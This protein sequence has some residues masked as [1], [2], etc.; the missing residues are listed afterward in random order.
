MWRKK[1]KKQQQW[2]GIY[3][4]GKRVPCVPVLLHVVTVQHP[5]SSSVGA[6]TLRACP[7][8]LFFFFCTSCSSAAYYVWGDVPLCARWWVSGNMQGGGDCS[9]CVERLLG[10]FWQIKWIFINL[11]CY[12]VIC[13]D[14]LLCLCNMNYGSISHIPQSQRARVVH[15]T[16]IKHF[17]ALKKLL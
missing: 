3:Q 6:L 9:K 1:T 2:R 15:G 5:H 17:W 16:V 8:F 12:W 13:Y 10:D 7:F 14:D 11:I 4:K